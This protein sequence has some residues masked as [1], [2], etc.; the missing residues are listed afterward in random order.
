MKRTPQRE[1]AAAIA[2]LCLSCHGCGP[3][4]DCKFADQCT[5]G[6]AVPERC[7]H[8]VAT[9][10]SIVFE[11]RSLNTP[12]LTDGTLEVVVSDPEDR[13]VPLRKEVSVQL[14]PTT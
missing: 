1:L 14:G 2:A 5:M 9:G 13:F 11:L 7:Y 12:S 4:N 8:A 6:I 3:P 10:T